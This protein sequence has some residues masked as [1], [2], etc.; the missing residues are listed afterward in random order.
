MPHMADAS[1]CPYVSLPKACTHPRILPIAALYLVVCV[2][3]WLT[4]CALHMTSQS[5]HASLPYTLR[6]FRLTQRALRCPPYNHGHPSLMMRQSCVIG[7]IAPHYVLLA[8]LLCS[9]YPHGL[10]SFVRHS[11]IVFAAPPKRDKAPE[12]LLHSHREYDEAC[13]EYAVPVWRVVPSGTTGT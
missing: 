12:G 3:A 8:I 6:G 4:A 7:A 5:L 10:Y 13:K 2:L 9:P 11:G 1:G